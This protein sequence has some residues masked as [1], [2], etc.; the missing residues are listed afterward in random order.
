MISYLIVYALGVVTPILFKT[1]AY[2]KLKRRI[3]QK[4]K[5]W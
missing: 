4:V 2:P 5:E 1:F 3:K